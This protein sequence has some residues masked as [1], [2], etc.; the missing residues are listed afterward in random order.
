MRPRYEHF[1][2]NP[3]SFPTTP[4]RRW[5]VV[6]NEQGLSS[7]DLDLDLDVDLAA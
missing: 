3:C 1:P 4:P 2:L 6:G 7:F 5:G